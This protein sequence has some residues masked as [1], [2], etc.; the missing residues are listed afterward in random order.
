MRALK[1]RSAIIEKRHYE[2]S[3]AP[4][5]G[6]STWAAPQARDLV[7]LTSRRGWS[8][9]V[10]TSE[11]EIHRHIYKQGKVLGDGRALHVHPVGYWGALSA[12]PPPSISV[13]LS[14]CCEALSRSTPS[15]LHY[16]SIVLHHSGLES[17]LEHVDRWRR[18]P[19]TYSDQ[20]HMLH[21][22]HA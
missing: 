14:S 12:Q 21:C 1:A 17:A 9:E 19:D 5:P 7:A 15:T 10:S 2:R 20:R 13:H 22:T 4:Q 11:T 6:D 8:S 18:F 3:V 16:Y